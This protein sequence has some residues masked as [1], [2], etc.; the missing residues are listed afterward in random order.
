MTKNAKCLTLLASLLVLSVGVNFIF[1]GIDGG[2]NSHMQAQHAKPTLQQT[3]AAECT[4]DPK[5]CSRAI[6]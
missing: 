4:P 2:S 1:I 3:S 6:R 5:N